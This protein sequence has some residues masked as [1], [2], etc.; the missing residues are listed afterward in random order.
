MLRKTTKTLLAAS[1]LTLSA[2]ASAQMNSETQPQSYA[3]IPAI[4]FPGTVAPQSAGGNGSAVLWAYVLADGSHLAGDG[5]LGL[6]TTT[7]LSTGVYSVVFRRDV[8]NN[9]SYLG[10]MSKQDFS[11]DHG[12]ITVQELS[13]NSKGLYVTTDDQTGAAADRDFAVYVTC[14]Q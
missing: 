1:L 12:F 11:T 6:S 7:K 14:Y 13:G 10:G 2:N 9:C 5:G 8:H 4:G 3:Q